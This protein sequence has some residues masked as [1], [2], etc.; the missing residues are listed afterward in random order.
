MSREFECLGSGERRVERSE[1]ISRERGAHDEA[2]RVGP[3]AVDAAAHAR[4]P[5]PVG[6]VDDGSH[7]DR[8][9]RDG[10]VLHLEAVGV[11]RRGRAAGVIL[12]P[13]PRGLLEREVVF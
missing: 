2:E 6:A 8:D 5:Q 3:E 7:Y 13:G 1:G 4:R 9:L 11:E 10:A 12:R